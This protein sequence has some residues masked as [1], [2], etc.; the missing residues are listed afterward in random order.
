MSEIKGETT[1]VRPCQRQRR[2]L[3][4]KAFARARRHDAN[5]IVAVQDILDN[6]PLMGA[7]LRE[8][9]NLSQEI[10]NIVHDPKPS[11]TL[12]RYGLREAERRA[13]SPGGNLGRPYGTRIML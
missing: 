7:K 13:E 2:K 3:K 9:K 12:T 5:D 4:A 11:T 8:L 6:L 10:I 1:T